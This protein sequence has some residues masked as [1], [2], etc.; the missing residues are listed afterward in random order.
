MSEQIANWI[1]M[2]KNT[3][4]D[5][6]LSYSYLPIADSERLCKKDA[7]LEWV[8]ADQVW[9][10]TLGPQINIDEFIFKC[11]WISSETMTTVM[12]CDITVL[13]RFMASGDCLPSGVLHCINKLKNILG[14]RTKNNT[15]LYLN[16]IELRISVILKLLANYAAVT[17]SAYT[18][19]DLQR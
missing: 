14:I 13:I 3:S 11:P 15:N 8:P 6:V 12:L 2:C 5:M 19:F 7:T 9:W 16:S 4:S 17:Q 1:H 18:S 10:P